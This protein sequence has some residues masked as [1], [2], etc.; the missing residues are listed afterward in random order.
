ML[1]AERYLIMTNHEMKL[2]YI[3][4]HNSERRTVAFATTSG[5]AFGQ[6]GVEALQP[7]P[8]ARRAVLAPCCRRR[9][10]PDRVSAPLPEEC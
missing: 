5:T 4:N 10:V 6:C 2:Q 1:V 3:T 8:R 7:E 9:A